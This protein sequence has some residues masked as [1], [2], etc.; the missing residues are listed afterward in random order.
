MEP[1]A[2]ALA[3]QTVS[4]ADFLSMDEMKPRLIVLAADTSA[5]D[6]GLSSV[7]PAPS[8]EPFKSQTC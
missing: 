8:S 1:C 2:I 7:F 3:I 5:S 6:S 4:K